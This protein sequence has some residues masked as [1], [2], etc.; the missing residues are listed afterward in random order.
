MKGVRSNPLW[1]ILRTAPA[2]DECVTWNYARLPDPRP[3][4]QVRYDGRLWLV[5]RLAYTLHVGPV[6]DDLDVCHSCDNPPCWNPRHLFKGTRADNMQDSMRKG[7]NFIPV[8]ER[9]PRAI[10]NESQVLAIRAMYR[11]KTRGLG[12]KCIARMFGVHPSTIASILY[13]RNWSHV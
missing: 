12:Y 8:G 5:H 7:R 9:S 10:L 13:R 6:A 4:G 2:T 1:H 3:Y 11:P